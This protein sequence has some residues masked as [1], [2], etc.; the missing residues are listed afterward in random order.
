LRASEAPWVKEMSSIGEATFGL[1]MPGR[2]ADGPDL[3]GT[4]TGSLGML[5][6]SCGEHRYAQGVDDS[7]DTFLLEARYTLEAR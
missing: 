5:S 2:V 1:K 3:F 6:S 4:R 7:G